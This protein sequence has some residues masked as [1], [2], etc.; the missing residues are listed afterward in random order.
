MWHSALQVHM[1]LF[2][3]L[4]GFSCTVGYGQ[5]QYQRTSLCCGPC[6]TTSGCHCEQCKGP[7]TYDDRTHPSQLCYSLNLP[8]Q[9]SAFGGSLPWEN[10]YMN[11]PK[12]WPRG[13]I[14]FL[15]ILLRADDKNPTRLP[16][17]LP[18]CPA[19]HTVGAQPS[20]WPFCK[21]VLGLLSCSLW[22]SDVGG[23][24]WF[25]AKQGLLDC[26]NIVLL[27]SFIPQVIRIFTVI[28]VIWK[29]H[30]THI[31]RILV[32]A[33]KQCSKKLSLY[34][35]LAYYFEIAVGMVLM[36]CLDG[37]AGYWLVTAWPITRLPVFFIGICAGLICNRI[38]TGNVDALDCKRI[39]N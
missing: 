20:L 1:P 4:S 12:E 38:R 29:L 2:F 28:E 23:V 25:W 27:L 18:L 36:L 31:C 35:A 24:V 39:E 15:G 37:E 32:F 5:K 34:M 19:P 16:C 30:H 8:L 3:L 33:Q 10:S 22:S 14:W 13:G 11:G 17:L 26:V 7:F 6:R 21:W 9:V